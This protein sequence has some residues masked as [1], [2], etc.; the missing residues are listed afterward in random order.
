MHDVS[1]IELVKL[2]HEYSEV[3]DTIASDKLGPH[4]TCEE[5]RNIWSRHCR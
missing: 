4:T 3:V 2:G 5:F 1:E